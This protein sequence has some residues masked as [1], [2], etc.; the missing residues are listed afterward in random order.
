M[1]KPRLST[2]A[3]GGANSLNILGIR[4]DT[5]GCGDGVLLEDVATGVVSV[6]AVLPLPVL[7]A[8]AGTTGRD[9][10][11]KLTDAVAALLEEP[12]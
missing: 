12:V 10:T 4:E 9:G 11:G 2:T 1:L 3:A 6:V 5:T 8:A 7:V